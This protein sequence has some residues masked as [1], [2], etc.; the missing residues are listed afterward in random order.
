MHEPVRDIILCIL[1][2]WVLGLLARFFRRRLILA[3][4]IAGFF[5]GPFGMGWVN[6]QE[7]ISI[8]YGDISN[9][10]TLVLQTRRPVRAV[11]PSVMRLARAQESG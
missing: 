9:V 7:S 2:T 8:V 1:F 10:D 5:I 6:S 11:L 4:L 3:Y